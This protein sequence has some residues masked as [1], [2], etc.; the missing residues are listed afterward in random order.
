MERLKPHSKK[1]IKHLDLRLIFKQRLKDAQE[2]IVPNHT[3]VW[4][5]L[6]RV[7]L[8]KCPAAWQIHFGC[9]QFLQTKHTCRL[10]QVPHATC[11]NVEQQRI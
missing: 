3:D 4:A 1:L 5:A 2:V 8:K 6:A 7:Y 9:A 11:V 10:K